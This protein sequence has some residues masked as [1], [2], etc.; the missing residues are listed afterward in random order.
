MRVVGWRAYYASGYTI[1]NVAAAWSK[2]PRD[3]LVGVVVFHDRP[4]RTLVMG[5]DWVWMEDGQI[6]GSGSGEWGEWAEPPD[7]SCNDC[8]KRGAAMPDDD[9]EGL[10]DKML[11]DK[12]WP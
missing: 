8:L 11:E 3:Q 7:V 9:W 4:Y 5:N 10:Q 2:I 1:S 6:H 12:N